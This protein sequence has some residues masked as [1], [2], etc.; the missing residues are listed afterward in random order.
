MIKLLVVQLVKQLF[1]V[2][3]KNKSFVHIMHVIE[4]RH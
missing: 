1:P 2:I 4:L 3:D